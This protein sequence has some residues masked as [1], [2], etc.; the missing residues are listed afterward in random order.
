MKI[1][2]IAALSIA[3]AAT[4]LPV[5]AIAHA[6]TPFYDFQS[7]SG[8]IHCELTGDYKDNPYANCTV[9][10]STYAGQLCQEPGLVIP[11]FVVAQGEPPVDPHHC[12]GINGGVAT[13]PTLDYGQTRS[14]GTITCDSEPSGVTCTDSSTGHF[15]RVSGDSY[16]L[17]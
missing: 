9:Q 11:Q 5:A 2:M 13:L 14:L 1:K 16:Q 3:T 8:N 12:V 17:G 10:Q 4:A 7:P 6:N 15:F